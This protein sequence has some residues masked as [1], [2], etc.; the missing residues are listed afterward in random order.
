MCPAVLLLPRPAAALG[1]PPL[2]GSC[3]EAT[4]ETA[5]YH[6]TVWA[7]GFT[8][9]APAELTAVVAVGILAQLLGRT[10]VEQSLL[11]IQIY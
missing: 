8:Y 7:A 11:Q 2:L 1:L 6:V 3:H 9:Q 4:T 10:A 5:R